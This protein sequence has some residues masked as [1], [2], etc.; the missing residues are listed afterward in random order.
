[1]EL[2][3][4]FILSVFGIGVLMTIYVAVESAVRDIL[5]E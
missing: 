3:F 5:D 1:M 2:I 4:G